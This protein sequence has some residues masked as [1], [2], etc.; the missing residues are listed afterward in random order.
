[1]YQIT[2]QYQFYLFLQHHVHSSLY[3]YL[4]QYNLITPHQSRFKPLHSCD[5]TL[6]KM[7]GNWLKNNVDGLIIG[8][9]KMM[10]Q[11]L[12]AYGIQGERWYLVLHISA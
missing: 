2:D 12:A 1:M 10:L 6:V 8:L 11:R 4:N 5:T 7:T 3:T 9:I